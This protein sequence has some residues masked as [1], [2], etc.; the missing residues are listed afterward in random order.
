MF[1]RR[2]SARAL[3]SAERHSP[4]KQV[5]DYP[6]PS[7]LRGVPEAGPGTRGCGRDGLSSLLGSAGAGSWRL[8]SPPACRGSDRR[9]G[10]SLA[11]C[12]RAC[13]GRTRVGTRDTAPL[14]RA[15][16]AAPPNRREREFDSERR[17]P[18]HPA[19]T[20]R[21]HPLGGLALFQVAR[22]ISPAQHPAFSTSQR[23]FDRHALRTSTRLWVCGARATRPWTAGGRQTAAAPPP[24]HRLVSRPWPHKP[25]SLP[26]D[27]E[28]GRLPPM[29]TSSR[30]R[31]SN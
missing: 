25:H 10:S 7:R 22:L 23:V 14:G 18:H 24:A 30:P 16:A 31:P 17:A 4:K 2:P 19:E 11:P 15:Q 1:R 8:Y 12:C 6:H 27:L 21:H 29:N 9:P 13:R 20:M 3:R 28:L 26:Y 5:F